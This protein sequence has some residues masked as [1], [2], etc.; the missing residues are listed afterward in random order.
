DGITRCQITNSTIAD[1]GKYGI[2]IGVND[3]EKLE[4]SGN[5]IYNKEGIYISA[6]TISENK[7]W[8]EKSEVFIIGGSINING[9]NNPILTILPGIELKFDSTG[10]I[11]VNKGALKASG[12][13]FTSIN[14]SPSQGDW[15]GIYFNPDTD[16]SN[17]ILDNCVIEYGGKEKANLVFTSSSP[18]ISN[19]IIKNS[20]I[21]GIYCTTSASPLIKNNIIESNNYGI[22]IDKSSRPDV[23]NNTFSNNSEYAIRASI[24]ALNNINTNSFN[25]NGKLGIKVIGGKLEQ[26]I[27]I[28][29]ENQR[30]DVYEEMICVYKDTENPYTLAIEPGVEMR[31]D[32]MCGIQVSDDN[33]EYNFPWDRRSSKKGIL[34]AIGTDT[35]KIKFTSISENPAPGDWAFISFYE[36]AVNYDTTTGA[37]SILENCAIEYAGGLFKYWKYQGMLSYE[38]VT[39]YMNDGIRISGV[40]LKIN[41]CEIKDS[42]GHGIGLSGNSAPIISNNEIKN[43]LM[44]GIEVGGNCAPIITN[45]KISTNSEYGILSSGFDAA[46]E[47]VGNNIITN[48][49][50]AIKANINNVN[51]INNNVIRDNKKI[52]IELEGGTV[53]KDIIFKKEHIRY[54]VIS[55]I[56]VYNYGNTTI[57]PTLT[58]E[59]GVEVRFSN[60]YGLRIG[61]VRNEDKGILRAIGTET[62]KIIFTANTDTPIRGAWENIYLDNGA[63]DYDS[64]TG[65]GTILENCIIEYGGVNPDRTVV[66]NIYIN[67]NSPKISKCEIREGRGDGIK[68][69]GA[70]SLLLNSNVHNNDGYGINSSVSS[71]LI[72][73]TVIANNS[74]GGIYL[75]YSPLKINYSYI[76]DNANYGINNIGP[77]LIDAKYNWW[78][79]ISGPLDDNDDRNT[80]GLYNPKGKGSRVTNKINYSEWRMPLEIETDD[81]MWER[82]Q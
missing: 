29:K 68:I 58:I 48:G 81:L 40:S 28:K 19:C 34:R 51:R 5:N 49:K 30:Y 47:I 32:N 41:K 45:N 42:R 69:Y 62:E 14:D 18:T 72:L 82:E 63:I 36:G 31:F 10:S 1:N 70:N 60:Y 24:N 6:G 8:S 78:G 7:T 39:G 57:I 22:R 61:F 35:E 55:P 66:E 17:T 3:L 33:W 75:N 25:N 13:K 16:D 38:L 12:S 9:L 54:D 53:T 20:K 67:N 77:N 46:P 74:S 50:Y 80:G 26:D 79:D 23:S 56:F 37:G 71:L 11:N 43:N 4:L 59:P 52:G 73:N 76:Y 65:K 21:N 44:N 15:K 2:C 27:T 64:T